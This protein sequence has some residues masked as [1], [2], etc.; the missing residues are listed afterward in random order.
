MTP[1]KAQQFEAEWRSRFERYAETHHNEASISGWSEAGLARRVALF[2]S[3]LPGLGLPAHATVL[4]VGCGG[5]TYVRLLAGKGHR[6]IGLDYS[7]PSVRRARGADPDGAGVYLSGDA[8]ALPFPARA[9]DLVV[10]IGVLQALG[11]PDRAL[12]E[13]GRVLRPGGT[14]VVE[15][16]NS[17]AAPAVMRGL[18]RALR[19]APLRVRAYSSGTVRDWLAA[20]GLVVR[21]RAALFLSPRRFQGITNLFDWPGFATVTTLCPAVSDVAAHSFLY[22]AQREQPRDRTAEWGEDSRAGGA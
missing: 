16:L 2:A 15:A 17:H 10:S 18:W 9:F 19:R 5:G 7:L 6:L 12:R 14:L 13:M 22:V 8:C 20:A 21:H 1:Q 11:A 4:D 3:L